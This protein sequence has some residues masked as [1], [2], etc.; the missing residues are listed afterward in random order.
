MAPAKTSKS[1]FMGT[2]TNFL[3]PMSACTDVSHVNTAKETV[4]HVEELTF[5]QE[6]YLATEPFTGVWVVPSK[7]DD[8]PARPGMGAK[9]GKDTIEMKMKSSKELYKHTHPSTGVKVVPR[10]PDDDLLA[11]LAEAAKPERAKSDGDMSSCPTCTPSGS[12]QSSSLL[13]MLSTGSSTF[14]VSYVAVA[15]PSYFADATSQRGRRRPQPTPL[16]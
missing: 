12:L 2:W 11:P 1:S 14:E 5:S 6:L 3:D 7:P 4:T 16:K 8:T 9:S 15:E 13:S 10:R